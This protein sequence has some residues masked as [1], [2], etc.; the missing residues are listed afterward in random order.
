MNI[1]LHINVVDREIAAPPM[2]RV[3]D[4]LREDLGLTGTKEGCGEGECG[5]CSILVDGEVALRDARRLK[6]VEELDA[7]RAAVA[8]A[9]ASLAT[10][11]GALR[12]GISERELTGV[13]LEAAA[14]GGVATPA[15]Q[16]VEA[17][18]E[19]EFSAADRAAVRSWLVHMAS[20][21]A[22]ETEEY[23]TH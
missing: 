23:S 19:A 20:S 11:V 14:G 13:L 16:A 12:V 21:A 22:P 3:L 6:T 10:A 1:Q 8:I 18:L 4:V 17:Q 7:I 2:R 9:D 5:A 15:V